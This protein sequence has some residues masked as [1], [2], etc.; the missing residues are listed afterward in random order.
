MRTETEAAATTGSMQDAGSA[1][2]KMAKSPGGTANPIW[3]GSGGNH[4]NATSFSS[5]AQLLA[6]VE[7]GTAGDRPMMTPTTGPQEDPCLTLAP[8]LCDTPEPQMLEFRSAIKLKEQRKQR[9]WAQKPYARPLGL[10]T[11]A[12]TIYIMRQHNSKK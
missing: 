10:K 3:V 8:F 12:G 2:K 5:P 4:A 7:R 9:L 1:I 6:T 11:G